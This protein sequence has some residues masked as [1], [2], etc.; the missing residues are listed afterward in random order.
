ML[1]PVGGGHRIAAFRE[2]LAILPLDIISEE[3]V[4]LSAAP[5]VEIEQGLFNV[6]GYGLTR[7]DE[8][9]ALYKPRLRWVLHR[10]IRAMISERKRARLDQRL[11]Q[12]TRNR[13]NFARFNIYLLMRL[14]PKA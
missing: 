14:R 11:N 9:M 10:A 2:T 4:T 8:E 13:D 6:F 1:A 3:D 7:V 5:S 12:Q